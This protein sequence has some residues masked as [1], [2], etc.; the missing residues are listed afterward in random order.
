[1]EPYGEKI[2]N[3]RVVSFENMPVTLGK[4]TIMDMWMVTDGDNYGIHM[5]FKG[6]KKLVMYY[7][8]GMGDIRSRTGYVIEQPDGSNIAQ[9]IIN[10]AGD[11]AIYNDKK[12]KEYTMK[13]VDYFFL[14]GDEEY[15]KLISNPFQ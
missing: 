13:N 8:S 2:S 5:R 10:T 12:W 4:I 14:T 11:K 3:A 1:M 7:L 15:I 9:F 6:K